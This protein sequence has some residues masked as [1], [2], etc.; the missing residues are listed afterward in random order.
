MPELQNDSFTTDANEQTIPQ[1][2]REELASFSVLVRFLGLENKTSK[3]I[4]TT[5]LIVVFSVSALSFFM[6][7]PA[8]FVPNS[9]FEIKEGV[10]LGEVSL[11]L[12]ENGLI[13]SRTLFEFC[14]ISLGG[15]KHVSSGDYLFKEPIGSCSLASRIVNGVFGIPAVR[16]TVPEG[17]SNK[18]IQNLLV[19]IFPQ[20]DVATFERAA[21]GQEGFL[22]P[23]TYFFSSKITPTEIVARMKANF[24]K[25]IK[26]LEGSIETSKHSL[27]EI[28]IMAS[29]LEKEAANDEDRVLVSGILWKRID[30][31]MPLQVDAT[32][33]YLLG[34]KS[35]EL[36]QADLRIKSGYNTYRNK[37]L[38]L[39]PIGNPGISSIRA[40]LNPKVSSYLYYLADANGV[41]HYAK[42]FDEHKANKEKYL[43]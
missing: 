20:F 43:R 38:P 21:Q 1:K 3:I 19:K 11:A 9:S 26:P 32:F 34:K 14:A 29:L 40:A 6:L 23:D 17:L 8:S 18:E 41:T 39:G 13:R 30:Q 16:V 25:K 4:L 24:D 42:T 35:S 22:F 37:G 7:P 2:P 12:Q 5:V 15:E 27:R 36:T 28:I 31:S 10:S 33:V